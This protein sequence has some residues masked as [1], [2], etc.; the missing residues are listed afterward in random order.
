MVD[1]NAREYPVLVDQVER[2]RFFVLPLQIGKESDGYSLKSADQVG[3][4]RLAELLPVTDP[5]DRG[6][7]TL[8]LEMRIERLGLVDALQNMLQALGAI[9]GIGSNLPDQCLCLGHCWKMT[10]SSIARISVC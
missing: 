9:I 4:N 1:V 2:Q 6:R 10:R 3:V 5:V 8:L 7:E